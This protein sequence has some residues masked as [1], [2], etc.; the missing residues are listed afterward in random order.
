[1]NNLAPRG[2]KPTPADIGRKVVYRSAPGFEPEEGV[3]TSLGRIGN[4]FVRYGAG[5]T[6][7]STDASDLDWVFPK[8]ES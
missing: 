6:S 3:I 2:I 1:M 7:A 5:S 8:G 4:V